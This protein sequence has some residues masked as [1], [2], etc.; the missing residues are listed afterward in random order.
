MAI[1]EHRAAVEVRSLGRTLAGTAAPFGVVA[2]VNGFDERIMPGAF[3]DSLRDG[4][5]VLCLLDH[6]MDQV[7]A[8]SRAGTLR[9]GETR[10]GLEF[11]A[12]LPATSW[13][14][15][16]LELVRSGNAGGMSFGFTVRKPAGERWDGLVRE[17]R[18]VDLVEISVVSAFPCYPTE[19]SARAR[20]PRLSLAARYLETV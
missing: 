3:A 14:N 6:R 10:R 9:L 4:H 7:L 11:E 12:D 15:D 20:Q 19:V 17:L 13:A 1:L 16:A 5:D 8:R 18:A 2:H